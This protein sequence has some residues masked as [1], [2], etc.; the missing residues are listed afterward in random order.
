MI[1]L[2]SGAIDKSVV[3]TL[4]VKECDDANALKNSIATG[5]LVGWEAN[6]N[7]K[8]GPNIADLWETMDPAK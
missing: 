2:K 1:S 6:S 8:M 3:F 7:G 4:K 5:R